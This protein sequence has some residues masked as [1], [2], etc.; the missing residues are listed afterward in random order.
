MS[1]FGRYLLES[2]PLVLLLLHAR[3]LAVRERRTVVGFAP[4]VEDLEM[5]AVGTICSC[6]TWSHGLI[7]L[8]GLKMATLRSILIRSKA[9]ISHRTSILFVCLGFHLIDPF[10]W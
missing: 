3:F 2:G 10:D 9:M 4:N 1:C 7:I 8:L 5:V 6:T